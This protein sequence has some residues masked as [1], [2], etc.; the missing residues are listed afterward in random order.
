[1]YLLSSHPLLLLPIILHV[2]KQ[3]S[4]DVPKTQPVSQ[5]QNNPK[6]H[7]PPPQQQQQQRMPSSAIVQGGGGSGATSLPK[8]PEQTERPS[9]V[10]LD[11][12]KQQLKRT[13]NPA[14]PGHG[15]HTGHPGQPG[16]PT[17]TTPSTAAASVR[18]TSAHSQS[19][20]AEIQQQ[21]ARQQQQQQQL[22]QAQALATTPGQGGRVA[23]PQPQSSAVAMPVGSAEMQLQSRVNPHG[24]PG[25]GVV[26]TTPVV[27][28]VGGGQRLNVGLHGVLG[29]QP[30]PTQTQGG[31]GGGL[32]TTAT[33]TS[34]LS[35]SLGNTVGLGA[36]PGGGGG[37]MMS[38]DP[39]DDSVFSPGIVDDE[40][41]KLLERVCISVLVSL[42]FNTVKPHFMRV[43]NL[44]EFVKT[45]LLINLFMCSSVLCIVTYGAIKT[46]AVQIYVTCA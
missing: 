4:G 37:H 5:L 13:V 6:P 7:P 45:Y 31:G 8:I 20:S 44:C 34:M 46:Y 17:S 25:G 42:F 3:P 19:S 35:N 10:E 32:L 23:Q 21:L 2:Y 12:T 41:M 29:I 39:G 18:V 22:Q 27:G 40:R 43:T 14:H 16:H 36:V 11:P 38:H 9:N 1:M 15:G 33:P 30:T 26:T 24:V 28:Q